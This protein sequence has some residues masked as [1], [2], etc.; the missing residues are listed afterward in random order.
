MTDPATPLLEARDD[1]E[2]LRAD[3][4]ARRR[5]SHACAPGATHAL[6]GANGA[7]KSTLSRV[8]SGHV[9][10]DGG[11]ILYRGAPLDVAV[12]REALDAGIAMVM[13]ETSLAP[14]LSVLENIFLPD[15]GRPGRLSRP[16]MRRRAERDPRRSRP[17][18]RGLARRGGARP[19]RRAAPA[20]R[21]RQGARAQSQSHHL[22]RA[23][24]V[25]EPQRGRAPVRRHRAARKRAMRDRLRL[26]SAGGGVRD[27]RRDHRD[28]RGPHG[29]GLAC[30]PRAST[31]PNSCA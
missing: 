21:D 10:R 5:Q 19:F 25:L 18:A 26:A 28:A 12:P 16:T 31:R 6:L 15:L 1:L 24:G 13:Q 17:G 23:D 3:A 30:R 20:R 14:D 9:R 29:R 7:G 11:E 8:I 27:L 22:R 4:R 2:E